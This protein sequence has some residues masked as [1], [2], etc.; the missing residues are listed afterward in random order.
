MF[1]K[2]ILFQKFKIP[3]V[4]WKLASIKRYFTYL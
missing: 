2:K 1:G 3:Q 4:F